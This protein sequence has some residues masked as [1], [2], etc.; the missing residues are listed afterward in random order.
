MVLVGVAVSAWW[1]PVSEV[2]VFQEKA[3]CLHCPL[4]PV[5]PLNSGPPSWASLSLPSSSSPHRASDPRSRHWSVTVLGS[6]PHFSPNFAPPSYPSPA[7]SAWIH[8][9]CPPP[10]RASGA[11]CKRLLQVRG[12]CRDR[13]EGGPHSV[14]HCVGLVQCCLRRVPP[15]WLA[16]LWVLSVPQ[17][18]SS[19]Q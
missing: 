12:G 18:T 17:S 14:Q 3:C 9:P 10:S 5:S 6:L 7:P 15:P 4:V 2:L 11:Q 16:K 13:S 1:P 8:P 19:R